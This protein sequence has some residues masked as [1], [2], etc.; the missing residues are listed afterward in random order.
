MA[1]TL[2]SEQINALEHLVDLKGVAAVVAALSEISRDK[3]AHLVENWQESERDSDQI[4]TWKHNA[5]YL[6]KASSHVWRQS[7]ER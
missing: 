6:D 1:N 7:W 3:V 2:T 4:K 5:Q